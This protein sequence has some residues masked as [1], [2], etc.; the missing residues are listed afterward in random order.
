M[1]LE[2]RNINTVKGLPRS[3]IFCVVERSWSL[4]LPGSWEYSG[5]H[6]LVLWL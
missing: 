6:L 1:L 2:R 4:T 5:Y 3:I